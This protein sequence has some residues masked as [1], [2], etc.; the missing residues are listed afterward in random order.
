MKMD[1]VTT[2]SIA[3]QKHE[4]RKITAL[5]AYDAPFAEMMDTAGVDVILVGDSVGMAVLGRS[6]TLSV[7]MEEMIH[8]TRAVSTAVR[9]AMVVADMPF[10][11]FQVSPEKALEN[12]G[13]LVKEGGAHA[14]KLEG[15]R[16]MAETIEKIVSAGIPVMGHVGLTPQSVH[17]LGGY[18][19][20]GRKSQSARQVL[21]DA[22]AVQSAGAF[23]VV[24]EAVPVDLAQAVT[25]ELEIPTIGIGAG[26]DCDGQILVLQDM[27]GISGRTPRF[28]KR[29][30][31]VAGVVRKAFEQYIGEVRQGE[32]PSAEHTYK[33]SPKVSL[34]VVGADT[35]KKRG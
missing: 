23:S 13:R 2:L 31:D 28:V 19:V 35:P 30:A 10:M 29:Y 6:D 27:L 34:K 8:H 14:V 5:T 11:S 32:F 24:I 1:K 26:P 33:P 25:A 7:T 20:Q 4:G 22:R 12:A 15:G 3:K 17:T 21:A 18:K 16:S 9:R